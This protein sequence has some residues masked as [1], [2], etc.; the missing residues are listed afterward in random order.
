MDIQSF[1][2]HF[3]QAIDGLDAGSISAQT[4]FQQLP[5]WD[6]LAFL[7]L[8]AM[9]DAE[10]AVDVPGA[11]IVECRTIEELFATVCAAK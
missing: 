9:L 5:Q 6:S 7:S 4:E 3:E 10:Y 11:K 8:L 2:S 1:I